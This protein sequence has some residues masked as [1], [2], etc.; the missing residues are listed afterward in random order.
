ME[1]ESYVNTTYFSPHRKQLD[2]GHGVMTTRLFDDE[3]G[4]IGNI[5]FKTVGGH[6]D[7]VHGRSTV[8]LELAR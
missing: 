4:N 7:Y 1:T 8:N 2:S 5:N 6:A 3:N